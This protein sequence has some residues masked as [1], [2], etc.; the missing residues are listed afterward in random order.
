MSDYNNEL[1]VLKQ[2]LSEDKFE[3]LI[4]N[5]INDILN[6]I[7]EERVF[8]NAV[9]HFLSDKMNSM[10]D[11]KMKE[12]LIQKTEKAVKE[13]DLSYELFVKPDAWDRSE[14]YCYKILQ[15]SCDDNK[16]ILEE[17]VKEVFSNVQEEWVAEK[18]SDIVYKLFTRDI[19]NI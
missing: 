18:M 9:S 5:K 17:R 16:K 8:Y 10:L 15:K 12:I 4:I 11:N 13:K 3:E 14:Q 19:N 7:D 2:H 6:G 1:N